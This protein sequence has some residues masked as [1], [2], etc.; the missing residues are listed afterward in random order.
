MV[1][2]EECL[3]SVELCGK[4][5]LGADG[6][7]VRRVRREIRSFVWRGRNIVSIVFVFGHGRA[8]SPRML[9][10]LEG[11]RERIE[12]DPFPPRDFVA[13]I[14]ELAMMR[15]AYRTVNSS[16]TFRPNA[17]GWAKRKW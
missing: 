2:R 13:V 1:V 9:P 16:L 14:V 6:R 7:L 8:I 11:D 3:L 4:L 5:S 12:I 17:R 10:E 15:T